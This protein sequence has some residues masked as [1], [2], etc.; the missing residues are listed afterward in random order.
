VLRGPL[1]FS[2]FVGSKFTKYPGCAST[3]GRGCG[4]APFSGKNRTAAEA[5]VLPPE[6]G[7]F[8]VEYETPP[9]LALVIRNASDLAASFTLST[10]GLPCTVSPPTVKWP[11]C[12][13]STPPS[14]ERVCAAPFNHTG[15][16]VYLTAKAREVHSWT[17]VQPGF[18]EA[19]PPPESPVAC[20][21][22]GACGAPMDVMLVPH[23]ATNVRVAALPWSAG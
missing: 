16:P 2:A 11:G 21:V 4:D 14:C 13:L 7:W 12:T 6:A 5:L 3:P 23:G 19:A 1:L 15:F 8:G 17:F 9:N 20:A 18:I 10:P 22:A